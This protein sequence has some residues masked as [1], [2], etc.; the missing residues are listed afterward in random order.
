MPP[1]FSMTIV[2]LKSV[3]L[4][5]WS[6]AAIEPLLVNFKSLIVLPAKANWRPA[7]KVPEFVRQ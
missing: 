5:V 1:A 2:P 6:S 4:T 7:D 3:K